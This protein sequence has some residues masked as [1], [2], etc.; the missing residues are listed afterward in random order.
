MINCIDVGGESSALIAGGGSDPILR[1]W[2]PRKPGKTWLLIYVRYPFM[3]KYVKFNP[4]LVLTNISGTLAPS[5]QF[6][7]HT[8]WIT[9][10]KWHSRSWFH[11]LSASYDGKVMLWDLRTA[12]F[13]SYFSLFLIYHIFKARTVFETVLLVFFAANWPLSF[14]WK[15]QKRK[16]DG[17]LKFFFN[18]KCNKILINYKYRN[19]ARWA[20]FFR[21][22]VQACFPTGWILENHLFLES[23]CSL[24]A[25]KMVCLQ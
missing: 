20:C 11:L 19:L 5:F 8:S 24:F 17:L 14:L 2:D 25:S 18:K 9:A 1:I 21:M 16:K 23:W 13:T 6:S 22:V 10:C 12:V 15:Y 7:S 4:R 3:Y